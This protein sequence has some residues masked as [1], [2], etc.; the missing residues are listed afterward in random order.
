M[1]GQ[2][3]KGGSIGYD[4]GFATIGAA[5]GKTEYI[6]R[7]GEVDRYSSTML[8]VDLVPTDKRK[9]GLVYYTYSPT[10]QMIKDNQFFQDETGVLSFQ[11]P[12]HIVSVP[13]LIKATKNLMVEGEW[14]FSY[15]S[16]DR[17]TTIN[18][19]NTALQANVIYTIPKTGVGLNASWEHLGKQFENNSLPFPK[20]ATEHFQV[21]TKAVLFKSFL[22]V[23]VQFN[24]LQQENFSSKGQNIKWGFDMRTNSKQYPNVYLSFKPFSTFRKFD[25]TL[26]IQQRPLVG[27]VWIA[28][29]SYRI[30]SLQ[31][32]H[33]LMLTYNSNNSTMD[34][35]SYQNTVLQAAYIYTDRTLMGNL[36]VGWSKQPYYVNEQQVTMAGY[37]GSIALSRNFSDKINAGV[38]Q[39]ISF[40]EK[41]LQRVATTI[42]GSYRPQKLPIGIR[43]MLRYAHIKQNVLFNGNKD[44]WT[45]Q[46]GCNWVISP[47][48]ERNLYQ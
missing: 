36:N 13:Y 5:I 43:L 19:D 7:T 45:G 11:S 32:V 20:A 14:A 21:G 16:S 26:T 3:L 15:R 48:Q 37:F 23:G 44:I 46:L 1:S 6:S 22:N 4:I 25:D 10:K 42:T 35:I 28:R 8:R 40:N 31:G 24:Y 39:D 27:A 12:T 33:R 41:G 2:T 47:K 29:T 30:K 9:V 18:Y 38:G 17:K 34:T